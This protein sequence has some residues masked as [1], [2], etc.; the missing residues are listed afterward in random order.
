MG[1]GSAADLV[2]VF[3]LLGFG[4]VLLALPQ[5]PALMT[6]IGMGTFG[7]LPAGTLVATPATVL[8]P[9]SRAVGMGLFWTWSHFGMGA[10]PPVAGWLQDATERETTALYFAGIMAL[11]AV[12]CWRAFQVFARNAEGPVATS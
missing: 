11:L 4:G 8:R 10:L 1:L 2:A 5:A 7:G 6:L 12:P 9:E 3:G